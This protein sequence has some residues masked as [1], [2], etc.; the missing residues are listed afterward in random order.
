MLKILLSSSVAG[1]EFNLIWGI[2]EI[3]IAYFTMTGKINKD[4]LSINSTDVHKEEIATSKNSKYI[5]DLRK[6]I[7]FSKI[8]CANHHFKVRGQKSFLRRT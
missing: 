3:N 4:K 2:F 1:L 5:K 7:I 6:T 8:F